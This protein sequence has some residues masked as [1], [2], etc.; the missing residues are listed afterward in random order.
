MVKGG[1]AWQ[2]GV[3]VPKWDVCGRRG[4]AMHGKGGMHGEG[5]VCMAKG[6]VRGEGGHV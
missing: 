6:I 1:C 5:V 4:E 3:C 2:R